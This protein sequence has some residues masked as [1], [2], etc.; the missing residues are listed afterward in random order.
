MSDQDR[1]AALE[2]TV[3]GLEYALVNTVALA[4]AGRTKQHGDMTK[5]ADFLTEFG[6]RTRQI[7]HDHV[8]AMAAEKGLDPAVA[9]RFGGIAAGVVDR[10]FAKAAE[11]LN[12]T[13]DAVLSVMD[14]GTPT[15][16]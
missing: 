5:W 3:A 11:N 4:F 16:Q 15:A 9:E 10:V 14:A 6:Q 1:I 8:R 2:A 7:Y 12:V 13:A